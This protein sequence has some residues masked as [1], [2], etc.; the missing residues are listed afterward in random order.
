MS[1][2]PNFSSILDEAPS[3]VVMPKPLP[4]GTYLCTIKDYEQGHSKR[5]QTPYVRFIFEPVAPLDDVDAEALA[6]AG[7]TEGKTLRSDY[8]LTVAAAGRLDELHEHAGINLVEAAAA[9]ITRRDRNDSIINGQVLVVV[10]HRPDDSD[11]RRIWTDVART[12]PV[13]A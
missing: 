10:K 12:A 13:N 2:A 1:T 4:V 6:E 7:G 11:P 5:N 8:W 9:G 3:E